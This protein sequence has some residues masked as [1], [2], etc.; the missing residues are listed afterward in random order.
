M[1]AAVQNAPATLFRDSADARAHSLVLSYVLLGWPGSFVLMGSRSTA[2]EILGV[3][4]C[5]HTMVLA[6]Y[7]IHEAAHQTLFISRRAQSV[8]LR[9][10]R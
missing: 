2:L 8:R 5:A 7:L 10:R 1:N 9:R 3:L 6:A 4:L